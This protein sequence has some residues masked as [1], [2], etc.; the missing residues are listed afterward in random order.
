MLDKKTNKES[1]EEELKE[2][3]SITDKKGILYPLIKDWGI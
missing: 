3:E 2:K 1:P